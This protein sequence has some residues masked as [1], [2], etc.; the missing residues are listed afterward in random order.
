MAA[1][2]YAMVDRWAIQAP[3]SLLFFFKIATIWQKFQLCTI[4]MKMYIL[5]Y[6]LF[7]DSEDRE[8]D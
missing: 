4:S 2:C 7:G 3:G 5:G 6:S 8:N 1:Y